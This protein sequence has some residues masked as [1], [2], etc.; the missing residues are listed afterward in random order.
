SANVFD[1][2]GYPASDLTSGKILYATLVYPAD[3][4]RVAREV[5][6]HSDAGASSFK[7]VYRIIRADGQVRWVD[8]YPVVQR[9][10][11]G[12]ITHYAGYVLDITER[13][14]AEDELRARE[15]FLTVLKD[16]TRA[17]I[18]TDNFQAML[19]TVA[20][21]LNELINADGCYITL[22][23]ETHQ[24][25]IPAAAYGPLR[26]M[27]PRPFS[28]PGEITMTESVLRAGHALVA[29]DVFD[30]PYLSPRI[31]ARYPARA[32]LGLPLIVG[33]QKLGAALISFNT[34]HHFVADEIER[35][36]QAARHIAL[37]IAKVK[38]FEQTKVQLTRLRALYEIAHEMLGSTDIA[39]PM[40]LVC[41]RAAELVSAP[42]SVICAWDV[43]NQHAMV[44]SFG[45]S[46]PAQATQEYARQA[47]AGI[48]DQAELLK[49]GTFGIDE[50]PGPVKIMPEFVYREDIRSLAHAPLRV[51]QNQIG[52]LLD[53]DTQPRLWSADE[54]QVLD[55]LADQAALGLD[56]ARLFEQTR[57]RLAELE[58]V[59]RISTAL[60]SATALAEM[61]PLFLDETL[62]GLNAPAGAIYLFDASKD[63]LGIAV[64]R[65]WY[66]QLPRVPIHQNEGVVGHV[67]ATDQV[68][69]AREFAS[70]PY[71]RPAT[72]AQIPL[73]YGG[74]VVPIHS[75]HAILGALAISMQLPRAITD[76]EIHLVSTLAEIAGNA[77]HRMHLHEQTERDAVELARAYDATLAGW[78][79]AL[80]LRDE[81]TQGHSRRVTEMTMRLARALGVSEPDLVHI[82]R[83]VL[84]HDIG[85]MGIPDSILLKPGP[86]SDAEWEIMRRHPVYANAMLAPIEYL[87]P[88]LEI[89]YC[90]HEHWD[91]LGYPRGLKGADIPLAARIFAVVD[92]WDALTS[93]R[94]YRP[95][96]TKDQVR[97]Y[98]RAQT[99]THF[100]PQ[101]V[102]KFWQMIDAE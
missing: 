33:D 77:I 22:W 31:A 6:T 29:E 38:S 7:Q 36:E 40:A 4:E 74:I 32:L 20:D 87:R 86:L 24:R 19:Q 47:R 89:P 43:A 58:A 53:F 27:Y 79:R 28:D 93:D 51:A 26:E 98:I 44:A 85:K 91:G 72:R 71:V 100:D 42:K 9:D 49:R 12:T 39:G 84:V 21:R 81:E 30:S 80:E 46:D 57:R 59:N 14:Q 101:V 23:D 92:V 3:L 99:G 61:L 83:G 97:E 90:H 95:A 16:I 63:E 102:E 75:A 67:F 62:A 5:Q 56:K 78:S 45:L 35:G 70:D 66:A 52:V 50:I 13:K 1:Q 73:G 54:L 15:R 88:A 76:E 11:Q 55:L 18:S 48:F 41:R 34:P 82:R 96:W 64:A 2:W 17:A 68:Y 37:A 8:D 69:V 60:R 25:T 10:E 65:G 94:P